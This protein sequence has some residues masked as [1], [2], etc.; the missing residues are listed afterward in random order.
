VSHG[1]WSRERLVRPERPLQPAPPCS[2]R[3]GRTRR[4][5]QRVTVRLAVI[6]APERRQGLSKPSKGYLSLLCLNRHVEIP[7]SQPTAM[8]G[9][10][11]ALAATGRTPAMLT[12]VLR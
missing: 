2:G 1:S 9:S 4:T 5:G 12:S 3:S 7:C 10:S 6:G 8:V 11:R